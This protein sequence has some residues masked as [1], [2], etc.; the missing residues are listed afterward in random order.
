MARAFPHGLLALGGLLLVGCPELDTGHV[1]SQ[2]LLAALDCPAS[3][4]EIEQVGAYR[5][6]GEGCG[7]TATVACTASSFEPRCV[8]ERT[9][10]GE[11]AQADEG[12]PVDPPAA[13]PAGLAVADAPDP[14][15]EPA[16]G[17]EGTAVAA[18]E[19]SIRA[20]LDARREDVLACVGRSRVAVRAGYA[21]DGSVALSLNGPLAGS[22]EERCVQDVLDGV[23]VPGG[24]A[25]VVI[26]LVRE[27]PARSPGQ[28]P[29]QSPAGAGASGSAG[30]GATGGARNTSD[31]STETG[32]TSGVGESVAPR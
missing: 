28:S 8:P 29:A 20:G 19:A 6:V 10:G 26:H 21:P 4:T 16:G 1:A 25:G 12:P 17:A 5:Y 23:R 18:I 27:A 7:R 2:R 13:S 32:P 3:E 22:P 11:L 31:S 30:V 15:P 9:S 24:G 14:V